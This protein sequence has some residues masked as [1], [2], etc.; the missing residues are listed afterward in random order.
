MFVRSFVRRSARPR[1]VRHH[2]ADTVR[3]ETVG[4]QAEGTRLDGRRSGVA[5]PVRRQEDRRHETG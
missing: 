1:H 2:T 3:R 5:G 4:V